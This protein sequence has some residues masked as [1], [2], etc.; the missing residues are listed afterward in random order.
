MCS[1]KRIQCARR[2]STI[3]CSPY[4]SNCSMYANDAVTGAPSYNTTISRQY[5]FSEKPRTQHCAKKMSVPKFLH[6]I[7]DKM[8]RSNEMFL[9]AVSTNAPA[10]WV[11][12]QS[13]ITKKIPF[14]PPSSSPFSSFFLWLLMQSALRELEQIL[15]ASTTTKPT[16]EIVII[17]EPQAIYQT[18][19]NV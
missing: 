12:T 9:A 4:K 10:V 3:W 18:K 2:S 16:D 17:T 8:L 6:R 15:N 1:W 13:E 7:L 14:P 5:A 19:E 11:Q